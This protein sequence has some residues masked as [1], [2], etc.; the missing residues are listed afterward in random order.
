MCVYLFLV[1]LTGCGVPN[2]VS[3]ADKQNR[4]HPRGVHGVQR[5][6]VIV[7]RNSAYI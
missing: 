3:L 1:Y 2:I 5:A 7:V 6:K 4:G